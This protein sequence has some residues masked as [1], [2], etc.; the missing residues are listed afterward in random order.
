[1]ETEDPETAKWF[2]KDT[3]APDGRDDP[4]VPF[5]AQM[6]PTANTN[7]FR[8]Y[9]DNQKPRKTMALSTLGGG[10]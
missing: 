5:K 6:I 7:C 10:M 8:H 4:K 1:M 9:L 2:V 3:V